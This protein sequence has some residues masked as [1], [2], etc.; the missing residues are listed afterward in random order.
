MAVTHLVAELAVAAGGL[1]PLVHRRLAGGLHPDHRALPRRQRRAA[2]VDDLADLGS[3]EQGAEVSS[4]TGRGSEAAAAKV[5][6]KAKQ[7]LRTLKQTQSCLKK[8]WC[9]PQ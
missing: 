7:K 4:S 5:K 9:A 1:E 2:D 8:R 3:E 6:A